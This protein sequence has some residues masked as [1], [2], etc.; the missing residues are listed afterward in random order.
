MTFHIFHI[1]EVYSNDDGSVQFIEFVGD[2]DN[3][4]EWAG[5]EITSS[6]GVITRTYPISTNL[7]EAATSGKS[8]LL[9]TQGFADLGIVTPDYIIPDG[10]LFTANG[11]VSFPG[12]QSGSMTYP[13]LPIDGKLSRNPDGSTGDNSPTNFFGDSGTVILQNG[14][15]SGTDDPNDLVGTAEDDVIEAAGGQDTLDGKAG[16]DLLDGGSGTDTAIYSS[17]FA[18]YIISGTVSESNVSGPDGDD[19]LSNIERFQFTDKNIAIDL[20]AGQA[21]NNTVRIIGAAF[22]AQTIQDQPDYVGIGLTL[23]D[24]GQS[25]LDVSQ[26]AIEVMDLSNADFVDKVY[27]N[28]V[29]TAPS[30]TEHDFYVGQLEGSGGALSQAGLLELAA[31]TEINATRIGLIELQQSG[32][33]FI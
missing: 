2:A 3:Q 8:V 4:H 18:S 10:F 15:I 6:N 33:E 14:V 20:D 11:T 32:V 19:T 22:G 13:A 28:V 27:L 7:P 1:N 31:N 26:L 25:M 24:S 21:A 23:F 16:N 5:H 9:A 29:G 17:D 30:T 12:M